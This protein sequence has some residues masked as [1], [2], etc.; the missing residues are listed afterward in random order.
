M[1]SSSGVNAET[2]EPQRLNGIESSRHQLSKT[3]LP[4][5]LRRAMSEP[6]FASKPA[7]TMAELAREE[8]AATSSAA[9]TSAIFRSK[10]ERWRAMAQPVEPAPT[11]AMSKSMLRGF[12]A[13]LRVR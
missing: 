5:T 11:M 13:L 3:A 6:G 10:R 2:S 8:P 12:S 1:A 4:R 7:W 9:S